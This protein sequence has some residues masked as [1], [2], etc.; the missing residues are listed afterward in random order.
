VLDQAEEI[1]PGVDERAA[2]LILGEPFELPEHR[3]S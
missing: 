2:N 1:G 3:L